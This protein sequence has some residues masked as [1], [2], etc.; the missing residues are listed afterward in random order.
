M[1]ANRCRGRGGRRLLFAV[2]SP[3]PISIPLECRSRPSF[4]R[5]IRTRRQMFRKENSPSISSKNRCLHRTACPHSRK[6]SLKLIL[7][8]ELIWIIRTTKSGLHCIWI[9]LNFS[10]R[11]RVIIVRHL[12]I[13]RLDEARTM[14][15]VRG[16]C[17]QDTR[18][19]SYTLLLT[20]VASRNAISIV[21][22]KWNIRN[23]VKRRKP[24]LLVRKSKDKLKVSAQKL[25]GESR[26]ITEAALPIEVKKPIDFVSKRR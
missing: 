26:Y 5:D 16:I 15:V 9:W 25:G 8:D 6:I 22:V 2:A 3:Q 23:K 13:Q 12:C 24:A 14:V 4:T 10:S 17:V 11:F 20:M 7:F 1:R 21:D 19:N 18:W